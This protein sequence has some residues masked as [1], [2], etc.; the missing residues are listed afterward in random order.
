MVAAVVALGIFA[1]FFTSAPAGRARVGFEKLKVDKVETRKCIINGPKGMQVT[2]PVTKPRRDCT[3]MAKKPGSNVDMVTWRFSDLFT[4]ELV[5]KSCVC[6]AKGRPYVQFRAVGQLAKSCQ[7]NSDAAKSECWHMYTRFSAQVVSVDASGIRA[8][9]D[10]TLAGIGQGIVHFEVQPDCDLCEGDE[11]SQS[12]LPSLLDNLGEEARSTIVR[13]LKSPEM[14][15]SGLKDFMAAMPSSEANALQQTDVQASSGQ[16][17]APAATE[18]R[19]DSHEKT[20][21]EPVHVPASTE[22]SLVQPSLPSEDAESDATE[23]KEESTEEVPDSVHSEKSPASGAAAAEEPKL[24][25]SPKYKYEAFAARTDSDEESDDAGDAD[26]SGDSAAASPASGVAA[27]QEPNLQSSPK[28]DGGASPATDSDE[29]SDD[30]SAAA[31]PA[32]GAAPSSPRNE[33]GASPAT[34]S[35]EESDDADD[36]DGSGDSAAASPATDSDEESDDAGDADGSGDSAAASPASGASSAEEPNSPSSPTQEDGASPEGDSDE[37][38]D[39]AGDADQ[40]GDSPS[41][42]DSEGASAS[43]ASAA[44]ASE[45]ANSP[46]SPT[47]EDAAS[48]AAES[49]KE[50]DASGDSPA[51]PASEVGAKEGAVAG[52][53]GK[54]KA[55]TEEPKQTEEAD[56]KSAARLRRPSGF[57]AHVLIFLSFS[58]CRYLWRL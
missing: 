6:S 17:E 40:S 49:D 56:P 25:S 21:T 46:S 33:D 8:S 45:E 54:D 37:E 16:E 19:A 28:H 15:R 27:A 41:S 38:S 42:G 31:S 57:M 10:H 7:E 29:E 44:A 24:P 11:C 52:E 34:D 5:G 14:G 12:V 20:P 35:D 50:S 39:D 36:E 55:T 32:S 23:R 3:L 4:T 2:F 13:S 18:G 43:P 9:P 53:D 26:G 1:S 51:S 22:D 58:S 47:D 48:A 30:A